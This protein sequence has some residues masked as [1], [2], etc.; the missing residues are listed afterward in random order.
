MRAGQHSGGV[1][2]TPAIPCFFHPQ[3]LKFKPKYEWA[4]G[5]KIEHPETTARAE[6]I[7][8][9]LEADGQR[10]NV[11]RPHE[12]TEEMI[13]SV[14]DPR[15]IR[16]LQTAESLRKTDTF[17]PAVFM[18]GMDITPDPG[19]IA[20]AGSFCFDSGTPLSR[21]TWSAARWS[22]SCAVSAALTVAKGDS[23]IAYALSRPPGHH[24]TQGLFGGYCYLANSGLA[25][26]A[27]RM[28]G[29]ERVA[30]LDIDV[31]HGN[32][33]QAVFWDDPSVLTVSLHGDPINFFPF[34]TGYAEE[35]G[36]GAARGTNLNIPLPEGTDGRAYE[37]ALEGALARI[38]EFDP[39][40]LI[41]AAGVDTYERDPMGN[42]SLTTEDL[43]RVGERIGA[44]GL[45]TIAVQEGGYYTPHIGR[46]VRAVLLGLIEGAR[47]R[48]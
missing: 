48:N 10:F 17:Y 11:R 20:H 47:G 7:L 43:G 36:G 12:I 40:F 13:H 1:T 37:Q 9:A 24:A 44:L 45:P 16:M 14:H 8:A 3:Q 39:A 32:G 42:F 21:E 4:F 18:R 30:V 34:F 27:L 19:L 23:H 38:V 28:G 5:E 31:H 25:A 46:N 2:A 22:A 15:L 41:V 33:T 6:G 35:I 29:A 26:Q